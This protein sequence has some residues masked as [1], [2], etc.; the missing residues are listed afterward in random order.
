MGWNSIYNFI[1]RATQRT[2]EEL[3]CT[4]VYKI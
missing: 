2:I 4:R 3:E 1:Y